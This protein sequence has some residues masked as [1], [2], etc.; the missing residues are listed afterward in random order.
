MQLSIVL[1]TDEAETAFNVL[2]LA[3]FALK[4]GDQVR[5]FL[6]G[7]GAEFDQIQDPKFDVSDQA[8]TFLTDGGTIL[9]CGTSSSSATPADRSCARCQ[10]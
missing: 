6:L 10:R 8:K 2:R 4:Q 3:A 5:L 9:A 7:K 1:S